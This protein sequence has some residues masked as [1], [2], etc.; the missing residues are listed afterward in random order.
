MR[1]QAPGDMP[2]PRGK[3]RAAQY[4]SSHGGPAHPGEACAL[5]QVA[6]WGEGMEAGKLS[7]E[8]RTGS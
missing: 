5:W 6:G 7:S 8:L 2:T 4:P 3:A 1:A